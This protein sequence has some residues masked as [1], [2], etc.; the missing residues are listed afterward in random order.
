MCYELVR[1]VTNVCGRGRKKTLAKEETCYRT[2]EGIGGNVV[3]LAEGLEARRL[4]F[5][6]GPARLLQL[7]NCVGSLQR[8][9]QSRL[10]T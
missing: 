10:M 7:D 5:V 3:L 6:H 2:I 9:H 1:Y 8:K 4:D